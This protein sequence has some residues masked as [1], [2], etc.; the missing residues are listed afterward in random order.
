MGTNDYVYNY[1][2]DSKSLS[3]ATTMATVQEKTSLDGPKQRQIKSAW[4]L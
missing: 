4:Q 3:I 1:D 2:F